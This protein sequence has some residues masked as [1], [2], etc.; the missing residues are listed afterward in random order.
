[1]AQSPCPIPGRRLSTHRIEFA[2]PIRALAAGRTACRDVTL[3]T[4]GEDGVHESRL[5][6]RGG[7]G[8]GSGSPDPI[9]GRMGR[10]A[11]S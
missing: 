4:F 10:I 3:G 1:M 8:G 5:G 2:F 11:E 9:A 7:G 6:F